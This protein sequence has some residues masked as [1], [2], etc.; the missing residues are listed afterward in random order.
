M[1]NRGMKLKSTGSSS[2]PKNKKEYPASTDGMSIRSIIWSKEKTKEHPRPES[3]NN[4][5][6]RDKVI[7]LRPAKQDEIS[8]SNRYDITTLKAKCNEILKSE[9]LS[10]K[11]R[12]KPHSNMALD[13]STFANY[14][15]VNPKSC[16]RP[17]HQ[18]ISLANKPLPHSAGYN[19]NYSMTSESDVFSY[20]K[21]LENQMV[22]QNYVQ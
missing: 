17:N 2:S 11:N 12:I 6:T 16:F 14:E 9:I 4:C 19:S 10:D 20:I 18:A 1:F 15:R 3:C 7:K 5:H 8:S 13:R 22:Y 21:P